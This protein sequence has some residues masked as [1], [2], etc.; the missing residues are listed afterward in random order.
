[1]GVFCFVLFFDT[2]SLFIVLTGLGFTVNIGLVSDFEPA[3]TTMPAG[4]WVVLRCSQS[5]SWAGFAHIDPTV[6]CSAS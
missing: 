1:M 3:S 6:C 5:V 4:F 2:E